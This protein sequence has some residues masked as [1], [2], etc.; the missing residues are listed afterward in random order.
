M[1]NYKRAAV[2]AAVAVGAVLVLF[3]IAKV[4][5]CDRIR[6]AYYT[7]LEQKFAP[8]TSD[9]RTFRSAYFEMGMIALQRAIEIREAGGDNSYFG[10]KKVFEKATRELE[11]MQISCVE[12]TPPLV[13]PG[14]QPTIK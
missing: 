3:P 9:P 8:C 12:N 5:V 1:P 7:K 4:A 10:T 13:R 2:G 14:N 11:E 6:E